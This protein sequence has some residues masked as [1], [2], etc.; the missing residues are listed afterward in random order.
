VDLDE[1]RR[2]AVTLAR[3]A[4]EYAVSESA[5]A[6]IAAKGADGDV[7]THVDRECEARIIAGIVGHYPDHAVLGEETGWHGGS[8]DQIHWL[9]DPLDGTNN[10]VMGV[11]YYGVCIT[12]C[13]GDEPLVAVAHNSPDRRTFAAVTGR[14]ATRNDEPVVMTPPA[15]LRQAT[16]AWAQGY[17]IDPDDA[18]RNR[19]FA[20]LERASKRV[21]RTW[22]P[23]VDWGLI[24]S[25]HVAGMVAYRNEPWDLVG[26]AF[27]ACE[28][29]AERVTD[30]SGD[31][32]VV[33]HP[34]LIDDLV[35]ALG[36][37]PSVR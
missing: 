27:I 32:E 35:A 34:A 22:C 8:D 29:G 9:V 12:A 11:N 36:I 30:E 14:G 5:R 28:A 23:S 18:A 15:A 1:M 16:V 31:W 37:S 19:A 21:L 20:G 24:A 7:V 26:G 13:R 2:L 17:G 33:A 6:R 10:Y 25:G 4:G 3:D